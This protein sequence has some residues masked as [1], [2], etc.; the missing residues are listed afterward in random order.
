MLCHSTCHRFSVLIAPG[1]GWVIP[2]S[3]IAE[4]FSHKV[5]GSPLCSCSMVG[6]PTSVMSSHALGMVSNGTYS[7]T[8]NL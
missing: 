1:G 5:S 6:S 2:H 3:F 7:F 4:G 8:E